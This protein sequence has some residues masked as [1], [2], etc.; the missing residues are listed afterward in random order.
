MVVISLD[1]P[2][3][4]VCL[5]DPR[6]GGC[7]GTL[8]NRPRI[9]PFEVRLSWCCLYDDGQRT[10]A[11]IIQVVLPHATRTNKNE[12][13]QLDSGYISEMKMKILPESCSSK[14]VINLAANK[15]ERE[16]SCN[17]TWAKIQRKPK[18][19]CVR[20]SESGESEHES[21]SPL[22]RPLIEG[23]WASAP[24]EE[25]GTTVRKPLEKVGPRSRCPWVSRPMGSAG[26]RVGPLVPPFGQVIPQWS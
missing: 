19:E 23:N 18:Q 6:S 12:R 14:Y 3:C 2:S 15:W 24:E 5:F 16:C 1:S 26:P 25:P 17:Q 21:S 11:G 8:P 10:W 9:V 4:G 22:S 7:F 13:E 20:G